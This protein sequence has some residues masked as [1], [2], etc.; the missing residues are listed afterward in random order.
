[1]PPPLPGPSR[2]KSSELRARIAPLNLRAAPHP[3]PLPLGGGEGGR[4]AG[5][6][7]VLGQPLSFFRM[8]C[9]HEPTPNPP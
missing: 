1:M 9:D 8:H 6:G 3:V 5:C 7:E 4:Q 2:E